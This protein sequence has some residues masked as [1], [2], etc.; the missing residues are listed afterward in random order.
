MLN[1]ILISWR[2]LLR[3]SFALLLAG[4][5]CALGGQLAWAADVTSVAPSSSAGPDNWYAIGD[6]IDI[7]VQFDETVTVTG[8]AVLKVRIGTET[9]DATLH[10]GSGTQTLV[11]RYR[12][13]EGDLDED[14]ISIR[15]G[16]ADGVGGALTGGTIVDGGGDAADRSFPAVARSDIHKV[17][18]VR[19]RIS[20]VAVTS[21]AGA[22][23]TYAEG[24]RVEVT[25]EFDEDV[26]PTGGPELAL[27]VGN[28][29]EPAQLVPPGQL[30]DTLVFRYQVAA[31]DLDTDGLSIAGGSTSLTGGM[32]VDRAGNTA[33]RNF[34]ALPAQT[35]H[36]ID[37]VAPTVTS[38]RILS[39][40]GT[41]N[42]YTLGDR[43][44]V[45]VQFN[46]SLRVGNNAAFTILMGDATNPR[47]RQAAYNR[48]IRT[49]IADDTLVFRYTVQAGDMDDDGISFRANAIGGSITDVPGNAASVAIEPR[50]EQPN[51]RV[52]GGADTT[53]PRATRVAIT[54]TG[55][56]GWYRR[57]TTIEATVYFTENVDVFAAVRG[58]L[59]LDLT[60]GGNT[61]PANLVDAT[62]G[63]DELRFMYVVAGDLDE[64]GI[65]IA[66]GTQSLRDAEI[67]D[68]A[69]NTASRAFPAIGNQSNHK[70]D[71]VLPTVSSVE[72]TSNAGSDNTY[73]KGEH[74]DV[75]VRFSER[76]YVTHMEDLRLAIMVGTVPRSAYLRSGDGTNALTFRYRVQDDDQDRDG[77]S[78]E[79]NAL[80]DGS[81]RDRVG[82]IWDIANLPTLGNQARHRVDGVT[83]QGT[84]TFTSNAGNDN[85][86]VAGDA[87]ELQVTFNEAITVSRSP[88][89]LLTFE[90][91]SVVVDRPGPR[92]RAT[93]VRSRP[94]ILTFRYVVVAGDAD[95]DGISISADALVEGEIRDATGNLANR[96]LTPLPDQNTH[97]VDA[98]TPSPTN[99]AILSTPL[100]VDAYR[101]GEIIEVGVTFDENVYVTGA[102]R[103][104]L[105]IGANTRVAPY[106]TGSGTPTLVF[107][108]PVVV[109]DFDDDG[110]SIGP[111]A[112]QGGRIE[113]GAG[114][115]WAEN[116]R[117]IQPLGPHRAHRVD[118][119]NEQQPPAVV[120]VRFTSSPAP[121][122]N[123]Y[124]TEG[125]VVEV[126][127]DFNRVVF[128]TEPRE[129]DEDAE[130]RLILSI[131]EHSRYATFAEGNGTSTLIFR[132]TVQDGDLDED[133]IA[134]GPGRNVVFGSLVGATIEDSNGEA[135]TRGFRGIPANSNHKV[136]S[137]LLMAT[138]TRISSRPSDG[139][140]G[141]GEI[142]EAEVEFAEPAFVTE[143]AEDA[144]VLVLGIGARSPAAEY[145]DGSGGTT[146]RFR[147]IVSQ[148]DFD[149]DGISIGPNALT[150]AMLEDRAGNA[151][152]ER[153]ILPVRPDSR[154]R[155]D[156]GEDGVPPR[157][158]SLRIGNAPRDQQTF[159]LQEVIEVQVVFSE[160][161]FVTGAPTVGLSIGGAVQNALFASGS[162]TNQLVFH[163]TVQA[164]DYDH[165]GVS[166]GPDALAGGTIVDG[167]GNEAVRDSRPSPANEN[168]KV[169]GGGNR[170]AASIV[171]VWIKPPI[172]D[173]YDLGNA[174]DVEITFNE[175]VH[176]TGQPALV[177]SIGPAS[178][179][180]AYSRGSG[181]RTLTFRYLV[182]AGDYDDDGVSI[183]AG[184][185]SLT[186]GT[187][188]DHAGV[189][190]RRVFAA[191]PADPRYRVLADPTPPDVE[192]VRIA[193]TAADGI[194]GIGDPIEVEMTFTEVVHVTG[195]PTL[196]LSIGAAT[197]QATFQRGSGTKVLIFRYVV[198]AGDNDED[199]ISI[200]AGPASLTGGEIRDRSGNDARRTYAALSA[201]RR[202]RVLADVTPPTV[203]ELAVTSDPGG[204]TYGT[205]EEIEVQITFSEIVH[206]T[207]QPTLALSVGA[208]TRS[209]AFLT[210][211]G[212][213][214]LTFRYEVQAGD[215]DEDGVSIAAG[216]G[217]LTGGTIQDSAGND[218]LRNFNGLAPDPNR[219][220]PVDARRPTVDDV[221]IASTAAE[222]VYG[223]GDPI[224]VEM[225]F[226]EV[227]HVT[228]EP[229]LALSVGADTRQATFQRGSGTE[230]LIFRY[231]VQAGDF[232]DDGISIGAGPGS[233]A[234]G[235]IQDGAGN[236]ARRTF[237]ALAADR[238]HRVFA[239]VTPPTVED[240]AV[241]S[242]PSGGTYGAGEGIE[243]QI[244][245]SKVVHVTG[246]PT[247][248]LSVGAATRSAAFLSGSG[249]EVLVF[250][251]MVQA[252]DF[253][254][255][256]VSIAAGP[257]SLTGGT[258]QDGAGNDALRNFDGL[259]PDPNRPHPVDARRPTVDD[260]RIASTAAEDV[261]GIGDAIKVEMTFS[262]VVHVTGEPA[263]ALS[264]GAATRPA[265]FLSG[266]G[267]EVLTFR[268][269]VQAG[270]FDEDGV[271][272]AAGPGSLAGGAIQDS[273]G[274]DARRTFAALAAD[275]RHRVIADVTPPTVEDIAVTSEPS[276]GTYGAGEGIEV[277]IAFSEVV[278]VTGQPA[279]ALSV[280]AATRPAAFLS[281][282][283]TDKLTFRYVVQA[284]DYDEDGVSIAAG[285]GSLTG[286][287]IQDGAG[288]DALRDFDGLAPDPK[289][290]HP[291][292][293]RRP[294]VDDVRIAS[295]GVYGVGDAILVQVVFS[296]IVHVTG[297]P[298]LV[299]SIGAASRQAALVTGSGTTT[300]TFRYVVQADDF[301]EDGISIGAGPGSLAGG[302]IQDRNGN[303]AIRDF[304]AKPADSSQRVGIISLPPLPVRTLIVGNAEVID[305]AEVFG[306]PIS[307]QCVEQCTDNANVATATAHRTTL[308]IVPVSEGTATITIVGTYVQ[309]TAAFP[310]VV[311][312]DPAEVTVLEHSLAAVAR[313]L[314]S[315]ASNTLGA[316]LESVHRGSR[317]RIAGRRVD[318]TPWPQAQQRW[319]Q[320]AAGGHDVTLGAFD[321][322]PWGATQHQGVGSDRLLGD[323][324]FEMSL[325]AGRGASW[326]LWGAGDMH[327]FE[328][329][330]EAGSYDGNLTSAYLGFDAQGEGWIAG[331]ALSR[332]SADADYSFS[333]SLGAGKG[334]VETTLTTFHPYVQWS[335]G[336][337]GRMWAMA[338]VGTG[339]ATF[340]RGTDGAGT[341]RQP[342]ELTLRMGMAGIR[343]ELLRFGG[344]E[345]ALRG[346]AGIAALE[347]EEGATALDG[348]AVSAQRI[349][350][351][352]EAGYAM[353]TTA[354][355]TLT[356]FLDIGGRFDGGDGDTG[357]GVEVAAGVRYRSATIGFEAKARTLVMHAADDYA[358]TGA[359]AMLLVAPGAGGKGLRF[360]LAPRWG[361]HADGQDLFWNQ[362]RVFRGSHERD[363][364]RGGRANWGVAARLG[365]GFGLR[366]GDGALS[367][368]VEYDL[369][370]NDRQE[371]RF[372]IGY[373]AERTRSIQF[374][375]SGARVGSQLG[376]EQR[377][378]LTGQAL[379]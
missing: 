375:L 92:R 336:Q 41:D 207:G 370:R 74:I 351:G 108:Y 60:V 72:V 274:N 302:T 346:D 285:P 230:V 335:L 152:A 374:D 244:T 37:A 287:T 103:L 242:E 317:A 42:T 364:F 243:V 379:F 191:L 180:A 123:R 286:G 34:N 229:A 257:G 22:D 20:R 231:V 206:V 162:G 170:A 295:E 349:R 228:G 83:A 2:R 330:P 341:S 367:P 144:L 148:G 164:Q 291:V 225:T 258:I 23:N 337:S 202:H 44:E 85:T 24:E 142:I 77:I 199:G 266:S 172:N 19:P 112:L 121:S 308:T 9:K 91:S 135:A 321:T 373:A 232:D 342:S 214:K 326:A 278:H 255:D 277:Q 106:A 293:A 157:V 6:S 187:I 313:G 319:A 17:D 282:S 68:A 119:R 215:Y 328:G 113:D 47:A 357:S 184:P 246:Q 174:I 18:G 11:F 100:N 169:D 38:V 305:L 183:G 140:Y 354:G 52:D 107:R 109:G 32:I 8:T 65:S 322:D 63:T 298:A 95:S 188:Q 365:Y 220:H 165:D 303:D 208:A 176:V 1:R 158:T 30:R 82:N 324:S 145:V 104:D 127:L 58:P 217:S 194:Y 46:E 239:D 161:V 43:I 333:S 197:R 318:A 289:R 219:P 189:D 198:Q 350:V 268:Y 29:N 99:V 309:L 98:V 160:A 110:V 139:T 28:S 71:G 133:G 181:T 345:L 363:E 195:Q 358:E 132:Y 141:L 33:I 146:L 48:I 329:K 235:T 50:A 281:G 245:F 259:A 101:A 237:A 27:T 262:E 338:G 368:F 264:V 96:T 251:Y 156:A 241:T 80:S 97:R 90:D 59:V 316:R 159:R 155:V 175:I 75:R 270:D 45:S 284:G 137:V 134:I 294:T 21:T 57:G 340:V 166:I 372:G 153:R 325:I 16:T 352:L 118:G 136:D 269:V 369:T 76:V 138:R 36:R 39:N 67:E 111:D 260:V 13:Q 304:T 70:V 12:V 249:T 14:G 167:G 288:N 248:A 31:G 179:Q 252:G 283:G 87:I 171:D 93:L 211:S 131:G 323:S 290:P 186:G 271:S 315:G 216:P 89:L 149:D 267:T 236:D 275:P 64:D 163:Y 196:A 116:D 334:T 125:D 56:N 185:G 15:A 168:A 4:S 81:I 226:S 105:S 40:A 377:W 310:I 115:D 25:L 361:G 102:A 177:L 124:Y 203:E 129:P 3:C 312:A 51:H 66:A 327:A 126:A 355:G 182:Q 247:L 209:A 26:N 343:T 35:R 356:P 173:V 154:Q 378:L 311:Q 205:G 292:D 359:S 88:V 254:E 49:S 306:F 221:R 371:T 204:G 94:T 272:I 347:T 227:V 256:G 297:Q 222:G 223:I 53:P 130:L 200:G 280:G 54:S 279:L 360:S 120:G 273:A 366:G 344:F 117:R 233:L 62:N 151:W 78:I 147:Y 73:A 150:G 84:V 376:V 261:Y 128:V 299:L 353:A 213:D 253:D 193:S 331:A 296:E 178:R 55:T 362:E 301:D 265:A 224:E 143:T 307:F 300:L 114:N 7:S 69:G 332:S 234:G 238:R 348:L 61:R 122:A 240:I 250:R 86:Y 339:E 314:L 201:D 190:A 320:D 79:A 276:G 218:A 210:G 263:L 192:D 212:T 10:M 5:A